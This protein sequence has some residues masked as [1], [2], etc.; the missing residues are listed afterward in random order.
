MSRTGI[1]PPSPSKYTAQKHTFETPKHRKP[2]DTSHLKP[3]EKKPLDYDEDIKS[4]GLV[5]G[6]K[7]K[8]DITRKNAFMSEKAFEAWNAKQPF[9]YKIK[10]MDVD[11]D[12]VKELVVLNPNDKM[13]AVNGWVVKPSDW[14]VRKPYY[15]LYPTAK[16]RKNKKYNEFVREQV[17][18]E[19][20]ED[21]YNGFPT[22]DYLKRIRRIKRKAYPGYDVS[23]HIT[24]P[25]QAFI[26]DFI[27]PIINELI[28]ERASEERHMD[29]K[30]IRR[31]ITTLYGR[32]WFMKCAS[33]LWNEW[34]KNKVIDA[35]REYD[36]LNELLDKYNETHEKP[37]KDVENKK[38]HAWILKREEGKTEMVNIYLNLKD[39]KES[40]KIAK[41]Y[42]KNYVYG[43][44]TEVY[45]DEEVEEE[46]D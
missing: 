44:F 15:D 16:D 4:L 36:E 27:T 46:E 38:F 43:N 6:S 2:I 18:E 24:T 23:A 33:G 7:R 37:I 17:Y 14:V 21:L 45:D 28:K 32:G 31:E 41:E 26:K 40:R 1:I 13:V 42:L 34:V 39:N 12:K 30:D 22:N 9:D 10:E 29:E 25:Y 8:R 11:G 19:K 20:E 3:R 5:V 35:F